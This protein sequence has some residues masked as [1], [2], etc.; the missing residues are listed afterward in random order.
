LIRCHG[1]HGNA[2]GV[3]EDESV[4]VVETD[5]DIEVDVVVS[6]GGTSSEALDVSVSLVSGLVDVVSEDPV[7]DEVVVA[8]LV[9][10]LL[11]E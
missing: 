6:G 7:G 10:E 4:A 5:V 9:Q 1:R 2:E 11:V 3:V 8:G